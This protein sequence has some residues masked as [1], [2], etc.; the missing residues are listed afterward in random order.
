[1]YSSLTK[2]PTATFMRSKP[3][4][5]SFKHNVIADDD[6]DDYEEMANPGNLAEGDSIQDVLEGKGKAN[7]E[8]M[9]NYEKPL[10]GPASFQ[11][12]S[13]A[14]LYKVTNMKKASALNS[15]QRS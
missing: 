13:S 8:T 11:R 6:G 3:S 15:H 12:P 5:V 1:M 2:P 14:T 4:Q 7:Y 9:T 10:A